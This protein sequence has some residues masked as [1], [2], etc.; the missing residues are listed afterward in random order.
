MKMTVPEHPSTG[1]SEDKIRLQEYTQ[2]ASLPLPVYQTFSE[3]VPHAP[4]FSCRVWVDG[5]C[6][7]SPNS[8]PNKKLAEQDGA[9][10]AFIGILEKVKNE[11]PQRITEVGW[12]A[13]IYG[14]NTQ[15]CKSILNEY[16]VK[17][18]MTQPTYTTNATQTIIPMFVSTVELNGATYMGPPG[19]NKK[20]AT[21][22]AA[23]TAIL[24][25]LGSESSTK[26]S[27]IVRSKFAFY[28]KLKDV[29]DFPVAP[30]NNTI[31]TGLKPKPTEQNQV[32]SQENLKI[33]LSN[34]LELAVPNVLPES[35]VVPS[36]YALEDQPIHMVKKLKA[37]EDSNSS[38]FAPLIEF[39]P[40]AS[41]APVLP[42]V[43]F[44]PQTSDQGPTCA[45]KRKAKNKE[46]NQPVCGIKIVQSF[47]YCT[48]W[49]CHQMS[50]FLLWRRE[51]YL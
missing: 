22:F 44:V 16:A 28:D 12:L 48:S 27:E 29:K 2:K 6:F 46:Q 10:H 35:I 17:M 40:A 23:R 43:E 38:Q 45:K 21:Q 49:Y 32:H 3:G 13:A 14:S 5:T 25:I 50:S 51:S 24:S 8:F 9:K 39:C 26:M 42:C 1:I 31:P 47:V 34:S 30:H 18:N 36:D 37:Q 11:G 20:E 15:F 41:S 19:R 33:P 4:R 7:M